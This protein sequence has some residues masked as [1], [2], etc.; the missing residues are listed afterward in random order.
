MMIVMGMGVSAVQYGF[1]QPVLMHG[2]DDQGGELVGMQAA[3]GGFV[4]ML[5]V[6]R[7]GQPG[8]GDAGGIGA[9]RKRLRLRAH[10]PDS[11]S[12]NTAAVD[13]MPIVS[14]A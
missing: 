13:M 8:V 4:A 9:D 7:G 2:A 3:T 10:L 5:A 14:A 12:N 6:E 1:D 11:Q